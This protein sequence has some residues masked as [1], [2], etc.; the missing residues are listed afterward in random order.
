MGADTLGGHVRLLPARLRAPA[1]A[2]VVGC[3]VLFLVLAVRYH[4]SGS[5]G[6]FDS[7]VAKIL[8]RVGYPRRGLARTTDLGPF[9]FFI[10]D[11]IVTVALLLR[12]SWWQA[13]L[14]VGGP[15]LTMLVVEVA[16]PLIGRRN[17]GSL[18][19]PS[20]HTAAVTTVALVGALLLVQR[21]RTRPVLAAILGFLAATILAAAMAVVLVLLGWH[22]ATDT[23]AGY[24]VAVAS[25]LG[26]AFALDGIAGRRVGSTP[27]RRM[28]ER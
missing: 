18:C 2:L 12:R 11:A 15:V 10:L 26:A 5:P 25:T 14:A 23:V 27:S 13:A 24:C 1:A 6:G 3:A 28:R 19:L 17:H 20:G 21:M 9:A 16:K 4:G 22:F 7:W 8:P